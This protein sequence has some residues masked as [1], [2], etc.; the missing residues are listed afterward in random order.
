MIEGLI[1]DDSTRPSLRA[2]VFPARLL[3][4]LFLLGMAAAFA[5]GEG[6]VFATLSEADGKPGLAWDD[7]VRT[8][9]GRPGWT[10]L[11]SKIDGGSME[12][13][14]PIPSEKARLLA[15]A[16][17]GGP[18]E[19][20]EEVREVFSRRCL[21]CHAP[22]GEK[23]DRP[24][25]DA[26]EAGAVHAR[27]AR[28]VQPDRGMTL[29]ARATS[30]HA[31]LFG[32]SMVFL[33]MGGVFLLT[34][35]RRRTKVIVLSAAFGGMFLDIGSWWLALR[36]EGFVAG[37]VVGGALMGLAALVLVVR[38]LWEMWGPEPGGLRV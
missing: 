22:G 3:V 27:V 35:T 4:T 25:A 28:Y 30:T 36:G 38:P 34:N 19:G 33:L 14:V 31:H 8:Y 12:K 32:L 11:A 17:K 6:N 26:R 5:A 21:K 18:L 15:W 9:H 13:H 20:F 2:F 24:F 29:S 1:R 10:L 16:G 37:V 23:E 7:L